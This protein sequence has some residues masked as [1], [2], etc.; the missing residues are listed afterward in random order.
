M[1][2]EITPLFE[3]AVN[4]SP[5]SEPKIPTAVAYLEVILLN[6]SDFLEEKVVTDRR[7]LWTLLNEQKA[8]VEA[9]ARR[10][11]DEKVIPHVITYAQF[12]A[13]PVRT[14]IAECTRIASTTVRE[15]AS[16][17][18]RLFYACLN[19]I[20]ALHTSSGEFLQKGGIDNASLHASNAIYFMEVNW[21]AGRW[22]LQIAPEFAGYERLCGQYHTNSFYGAYQCLYHAR[23]I[24]RGVASD[25]AYSTYYILPGEDYIEG[26]NRPL[27]SHQSNDGRRF[28]LEH[29]E[30][31][32]VVQALQLF[33]YRYINYLKEKERIEEMVDYRFG[34]LTAIDGGVTVHLHSEPLEMEGR[35]RQALVMLIQKQGNIL[36]RDELREEAYGGEVKMTT[37]SKYVRLVNKE[38]AKRTDEV[39]VVTV[40]GV[41]WR[42]ELT[43]PSDTH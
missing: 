22:E 28:I 43:K 36:E 32:T 11:Y 14:A 9:E 24:S 35:L 42:L 33:H 25:S 2:E 1:L 10:F 7:E 12:Y 8:K 34:P 39:T 21:S 23:D 18:P 40:M 16:C 15:E 3:R 26:Y 29:V 5:T 17:E 37:V 41:G 30:E 13:S 38:L 19:L 31:K 27:S 4:P 20:H 6:D